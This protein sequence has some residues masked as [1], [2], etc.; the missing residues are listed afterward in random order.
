MIIRPSGQETKEAE[1]TCGMCGVEGED[2]ASEED[3]EEAGQRKTVKLQDPL[4]PTAAER[5]EHELTHIP[6]RSW[7]S[8]CQRPRQTG[9]PQ[10]FKIRR[11][12]P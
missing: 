7:C 2:E 1:A 3:S 10:D 12:T 11:S 8:F 6:Y 5:A 9:K 4:M